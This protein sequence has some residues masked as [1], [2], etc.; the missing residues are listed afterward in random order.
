MTGIY[1]IYNLV[2]RKYYVGQAIDI[3]KRWKQHR[4]K[5]NTGKHYNAHLQRAWLQYGEGSF[6]FMVLE[7]CTED[8]LDEL[9]AR[10]IE[11]YNAYNNG[12]NMTMG[13]EG[14]RG[15]YHT[16]EHKQYMS[17]LLTGRV[18]SDE[19]RTKMS[20][21]ARERPYTMTEKRVEGFKKTAMALKGRT[22][23]AAHC[24]HI[25]DGKKGSI[26]WNKGKKYPDGY[27]HPW[28]GK[29]HSEETKRRISE[30]RTG[31]KRSDEAKLKTSKRIVCV[32]TGVEYPSITHA[33]NAYGISIYAI[34]NA[35][36][37]KSQTAAKHHWQYV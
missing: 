35:L 33:A 17:Q 13:G 22:F 25:S 18:F 36:R 19:T 26:P 20:K 3:E 21:A 10:Y 31:T 30:K 11:K 28:L 16:E 2:N 12:Y 5:L 8:R 4:Q 27:V 14:T 29:H 23:S 32:E 15:F 1:C 9:E 37:G 24:Q 6:Q 7:C 34:S